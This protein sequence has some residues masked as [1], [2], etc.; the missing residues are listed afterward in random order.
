MNLSDFDCFLFDFADVISLPQDMSCFAQMA[1]VLGL[2]IDEFHNLYWGHRKLYDLGMTGE[3][4][5]ELVAGSA[6]ELQ[7]VNQLIELDCRSWGRRNLETE[8]ILR[9]L[10]KK[11]KR[12]ALLSN[13]P[14]ELAQYMRKNFKIFTAFDELIFSA[15]VGMV[16]PDL[17]I[18]QFTLSVLKV[19][20]AEVLFLDDRQENLTGAKMAGIQGVLVTQENLPQLSVEVAKIWA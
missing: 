11:G 9:Q 20:P 10:K 13:L 12:I 14:I 15:E 19:A 1:Q 2:S 5:W 7:I 3:A 8:E 16:K 18:Y 4:Y 6:L 17:D